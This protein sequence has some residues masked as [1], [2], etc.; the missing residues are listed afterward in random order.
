M[1]DIGWQFC[2]LSLFLIGYRIRRWAADKK[3]NVTAAILIAAGCMV[4]ISLGC[5]NYYRGLQDLPV[6]VTFY[7]LNLFSYGPLAP[8]EIIASCLIFAGFSVMKV[9]E[10]HSKVAEYTFLIYLFHAA[11][12]D[13]IAAVC[14]RKLGESQVVEAI[15][16]IIISIIVFWISLVF[17][18]IYKKSEMILKNRKRIQF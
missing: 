9:G 13:V 7:K 6:D 5:I 16:V 17:A 18:A 3:S 11:V 1:W 8:I 14:R 2:F 12:W 15:S 10:D 4:N